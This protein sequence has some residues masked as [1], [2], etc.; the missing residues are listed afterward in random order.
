MYTNIQKDTTRVSCSNSTTVMWP[1]ARFWTILK[2]TLPQNSRSNIAY[3][4][5]ATV[6]CSYC[7]SDEGRGDCPKLVEW[8]RNKTRHHCCILLAI[9]IRTQK[10]MHGTKNLKCLHYSRVQNSKSHYLP[11]CAFPRSAHTTFRNTEK[12]ITN[13][14]TAQ[15]IT[16]VTF[17]P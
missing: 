2:W 8:P 6:N 11:A 12:E 17:L 7:T 13:S 15:F 14:I 3:V 9:C 5:P 4:T 16:L 10:T 1:I